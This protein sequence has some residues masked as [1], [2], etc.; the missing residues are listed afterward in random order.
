ML[1]KRHWPIIFV[2]FFFPGNGFSQLI[3]TGYVDVK[4]GA[5]EFNPK[6]IKKKKIKSITIHII[7]KPDGAIIVNKGSFNRY[8]FNIYGYATKYYYSVF[9]KVELNNS[10]KIN[11]TTSPYR[12]I[13][14]TISTQLTY[15]NQH[16]IIIKKTT[17]ND[18]VQSHEIQYDTSNN[19]IKETL[20]KTHNK[21]KNNDI[22]D[23]YQTTFLSD[24]YEYH[25]T[26]PFQ[27]K[28]KILDKSNYPYKSLIV[29]KDSL[30]NLKSTYLSFASGLLNESYSYEYDVHKRVSKKTFITNNRGGVKE[31]NVYE[32]TNTGELLSEKTYSDNEL[33]HEVSYLF[34][35]QTGL[36]KSEVSRD[37]KKQFIIIAKYEYTYY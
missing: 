17:T 18:I 23:Q 36:I 10:P 13:N 37:H 3:H 5:I 20:S 11:S 2:L 8:E 32:Y 34:D 21:F 19:I 15:D 6:V 24:K 35:N 25:I 7:N 30:H 27:T 22:I 29:T 12:Y 33:I 26:T 31:V 28:V 1:S 9:N 4:T 14:D 16:R